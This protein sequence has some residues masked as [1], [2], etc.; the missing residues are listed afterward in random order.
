MSASAGRAERPRLNKGLGQH[1]LVS[2]GVLNDIIDAARLTKNDLVVEIGPGTG[3][4][5]KRL[6]DAAGSV[7]AVE[8]DPEM[9]RHVR[10]NF[11]NR[12]E[13]TLIEGDIRDHDPADLTGGRAYSVVA[14]LPYYVASH[15]IR[16]FLE[17][18]HPPRRMVVMAQREVAQQMA[19]PPGRASLLT[20]ATQVYADARIVRRVRPGSFVPSPGVESAVVSLDVL[21]EPRVPRHSL[22]AFFG[23]SRAGFSAPRKQLRNALANGLRLAPDILHAGLQQAGIDGR[24]RAET[25]SIGEWSR[26]VDELAGN[27]LRQK[28]GGRE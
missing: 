17:S 6:L 20:L 27:L 19:A 26:L 5:T 25:L 2:D 14:N 28:P 12:R 22:P 7:I 23:V 4:L 10:E 1:L 18:R 21:T 13:L 3:L 8:V 24:R 9:A 16:I 11:P 15:V